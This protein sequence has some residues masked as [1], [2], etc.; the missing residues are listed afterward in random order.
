MPKFRDTISEL[1]DDNEKEKIFRSSV[2]KGG[3]L[4]SH[5]DWLGKSFSPAK[6]T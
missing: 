1:Y 3:A 6:K 2:K 5:A 4:Y